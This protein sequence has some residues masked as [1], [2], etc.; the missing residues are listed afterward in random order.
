MLLR[1]LGSKSRK[2]KLYRAFRELGRVERTIF[3]L[4]Y[5]SEADLRFNI[6]AETTKI[7]SFHSFLDWIAFGGTV[8]KSGDPAEQSKRMKYM[9]VLGQLCDVTKCG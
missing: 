2:N 6:R 9:D 4:R 7:E 8:I 1:K 5:I 3:L